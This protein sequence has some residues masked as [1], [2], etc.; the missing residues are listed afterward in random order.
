MVIALRGILSSPPNRAE[1]LGHRR[2]GQR[3]TL[4]YESEVRTEVR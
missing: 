1:C 4:V 3:L 2:R